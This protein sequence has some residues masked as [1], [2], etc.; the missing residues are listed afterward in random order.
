MGYCPFCGS[1]RTIEPGFKSVDWG[2]L[3]AGS[4]FKGGLHTLLEGSN[5]VISELDKDCRCESCDKKW[6]RSQV[7]LYEE[8]IESKSDFRIKAHRELFQ[9]L[10]EYVNAISKIN[11]EIKS[12]EEDLSHTTSEYGGGCGGLLGIIFSIPFLF[13]G[14][15]FFI[16]LLIFGLLSVCFYKTGM[17]IGYLFNL[18]FQRD[19]KLEAK[20]KRK[21]DERREIQARYQRKLNILRRKFNKEGFEEY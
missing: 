4:V 20:L 1:N 15:S 19:Q 7:R 2:K 6:H 13:A 17:A 11:Q 9:L 12:L 14:Q 8:I 16:F 3:A 21:L 10:D 5:A 18:V